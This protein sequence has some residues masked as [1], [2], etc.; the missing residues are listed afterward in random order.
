M[1]WELRAK[2]GL[3]DPQLGN[4]CSYAN[5]I[6]SGD[7]LPSCDTRLTS[8]IRARFVTRLWRPRLSILLV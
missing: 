6:S 2:S 5:Q 3:R 7:R 1:H 4:E 8:L